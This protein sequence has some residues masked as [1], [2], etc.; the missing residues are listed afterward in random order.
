MCCT[1]L[2]SF[3]TDLHQLSLF[4][5]YK[6]GLKWVLTK[7]PCGYFIYRLVVNSEEG[8]PPTDFF[9]PFYCNKPRTINHK[10]LQ[11]MKG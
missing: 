1:V 7:L 9:W 3:T 4:S 5:Q 11:T 8:T 10:A 2:H 6:K